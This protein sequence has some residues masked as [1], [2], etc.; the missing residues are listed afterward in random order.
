M[1]VGNGLISKAFKNYL[2]N[3]S[4]LI[5]ASGV[6]NSNEID[7][8]NFKREEHLLRESIKKY[9]DFLFIYFSSCSVEDS[10]LRETPYYQHKLKMENLVKKESNKYLIFRIP[11][12]IGRDGNQNLIINFL[13]DK[14]QK[15]EEFSL[16]KKA[17]RNL[18]D[19]EDIYKI[20]HYIIK[21]SL[22]KDRVVNIANTINIKVINLVKIIEKV[23]NKKA[24]Y[25]LIDRGVD[26][27]IDI[28]EIK[29][30]INKLNIDFKNNYIERLIKKYKV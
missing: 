28:S 30:I 21:N 17:S 5:F 11:Q 20:A 7:L 27:N 4:V 23:L 29:E 13:I 3:D 6:S 10:K 25:K 12:V 2:K 22:Y 24:N 26:Y 16:W 19:V 15:K 18:I 8:N 14:I 1:L 9:S